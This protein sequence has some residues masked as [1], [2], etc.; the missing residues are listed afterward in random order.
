LVVNLAVAVARHD[1]ALLTNVLELV[2]RSR[3]D[4]FSKL[5][6][7]ARLI[8]L[9]VVD[10]LILRVRSTH[11]LLSV[12]DHVLNSYVVALANSSTPRVD[13]TLVGVQ[14]R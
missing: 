5:V 13:P 11:R 3:L 1:G 4:A 14:R 8:L 6:L 2:A 7:A 12:P 10:L 9:E